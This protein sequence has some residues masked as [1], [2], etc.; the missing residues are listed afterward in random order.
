MNY[1]KEER[2]NIGWSLESTEAPSCLVGYVD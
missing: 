1:T 2:T